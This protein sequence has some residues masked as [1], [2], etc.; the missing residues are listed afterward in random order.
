MRIGKALAKTISYRILGSLGT[1]F[2]AFFITGSI[3]TGI[4]FAFVDL[5]LKMS[6][7]F[8]HELFWEWIS[9]K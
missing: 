2:I 4:A 8:L 3:E 1:Y 5:I 6:L 7:Y 9:K